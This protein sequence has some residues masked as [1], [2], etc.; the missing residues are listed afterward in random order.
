MSDI[1]RALRHI[2]AEQEARQTQR[3]I[4]RVMRAGRQES[5]APPPF[6]TPPDRPIFPA[7]VVPVIL[8]NPPILGRGRIL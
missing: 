1:L 7:G 2:S 8:L 3:S 6:Y 4:N 5:P